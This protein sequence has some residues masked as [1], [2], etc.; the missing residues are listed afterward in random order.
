M[1]R[2]RREI[3]ENGTSNHEAYAHSNK[4]H[5]TN[6][7][8]KERRNEIQHNEKVC[9]K[10]VASPKCKSFF[11]IHGTPLLILRR[12]FP[13]EADRHCLTSAYR[14]RRKH[15]RNCRLLAGHSCVERRFSGGTLTAAPVVK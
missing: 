4:I 7:K 15:W 10:F 8:M 2:V 12:I 11:R 3:L 13:R 14:R 9:D 6:T 1:Y 5:K